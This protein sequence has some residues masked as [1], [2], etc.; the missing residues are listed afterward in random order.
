[1]DKTRTTKNNFRDDKYYLYTIH[2]VV[3]IGNCV[4]RPIKEGNILKVAYLSFHYLW[5]FGAIVL[6]AFKRK[7]LCD[8]DIHYVSKGKEYYWGMDIS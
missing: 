2:I 3:L 8:N 4:G 1:M 5:H 7:L 6:K